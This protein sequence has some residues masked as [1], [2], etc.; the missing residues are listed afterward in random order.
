MSRAVLRNLTHLAPITNSATRWPGKYEMIKRFN[1]TRDELILEAT[2][3]N[4]SIRINDSEVFK[5]E[6]E[7]F[8]KVPQYFN[9]ATKEQQNSKASLHSCRCVIDTLLEE[10]DVGKMTLTLPYTI[11]NFILNVFT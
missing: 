1:R 8:E 4:A 10:I 6:N 7:K 5:R 11:V 2:S 9:V 3:E